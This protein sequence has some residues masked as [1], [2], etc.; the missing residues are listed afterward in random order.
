MAARSLV[1]GRLNL[2]LPAETTS[3]LKQL[4]ASIDEAA[5]YIAS[6]CEA[7]VKDYVKAVQTAKGEK[8]GSETVPGDS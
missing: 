6:T 8:S 1:S 4:V 7:A 3:D 2:I 5:F